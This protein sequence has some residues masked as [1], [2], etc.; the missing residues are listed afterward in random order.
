MPTEPAPEQW[1]ELTC[2]FPQVGEVMVMG[3]LDR[4]ALERLAA[5]FNGAQV[6]ANPRGPWKVR[7]VPPR[8]SPP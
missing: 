2:T 7:A 5:R 3:A 8:P 1:Y 4:K 6:R